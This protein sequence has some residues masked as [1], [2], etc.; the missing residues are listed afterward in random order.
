MDFSHQ[1]VLSS[2]VLVLGLAIGVVLQRS[3]FCTMGSVSDAVLFGSLRRLRVWALALAVAMAGTQI[4]EAAGLVAIGRSIYLQEGWLWAGAMPGGLLFGLGMVQAGGC[5]SRNLVRFGGGSLKALT[6]LLATAAMALVTASLLPSWPAPTAALAATPAWR[7]PLALAIATALLA[8]CL[9]HAGFR[10]ARGDL[11]TGLA[12]GVLIP[13]G[14]VA[15]GW[16]GSRPDSLNFLG[17]ERPALVAPLLVGTVL[18]AGV[19]ARLRGEFRLERFSAAG[20]RRRHILGGLLMGV[21]GALALG[22]TIGQGLTGVAT[23]SPGSFL[24]LGGMLAGAWWGV[25]QL[26]TGRLLPWL[27]IAPSRSRQ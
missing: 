17:L 12:L 8:F 26:E 9:A 13:L 15:T 23:L 21:G 24:A 4:L 10:R 16:A 19:M 14:W 1:L 5:V 18:G 20:E 2:S 11:A 27:P 3:H 7:L 6:A 22:C 25:K